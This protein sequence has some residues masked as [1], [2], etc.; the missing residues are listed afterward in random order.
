MRRSQAQALI[1]AGLG[2][3]SRRP[4]APSSAQRASLAPLQATSL[5]DLLHQP[6][7]QLPTA[8][9]EPE[10]VD[11][12]AETLAL[13]PPDG[14]SLSGE[15][16]GPIGSS[17]DAP[18]GNGG[19]SA[20][21]LH[22]LGVWPSLEEAKLELNAHM[23]P[24]AAKLRSDLRVPRAIGIPDEQWHPKVVSTAV[25]A[26]S[27]DFR[28]LKK[29]GPHGLAEKLKHGSYLVDGVLNDSFVK[30][31]RGREVRF[32]TVPD[33]ATTPAS[34][35]TGWRHVIAVR[36]GTILEKEFEMP[37]RWLWLDEHSRAD[38]ARGYMYKICRVYELSPRDAA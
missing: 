37:A 4:R 34:D 9:V 30:L 27:W 29:L 12:T 7:E 38:P 3:L 33:D 6:A 13:P 24:T 10:C 25:L 19:C 1:D 32:D 16:P 5:D 8:S 28:R 11:A 14:V 15:N 20:V 17:K 18:I 23:A 21:A 26:A 35:E 36:D 22:K 31:Y 2:G